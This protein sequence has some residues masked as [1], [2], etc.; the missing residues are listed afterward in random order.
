MTVSRLSA[1]ALAAALLVV[2]GCNTGSRSSGRT[3]FGPQPPAPPPATINVSR[4]ANPSTALLGAVINSLVLRI[5]N[6]STT[7][8]ASLGSLTVVAS[9]TVDESVVLTSATLRHDLNLDGLVDQNDPQLATVAAPAFAANNGSVT[10]TLNPPLQIPTLDA[11]QVI[12]TVET[13]AS[14]GA[15]AQTAF[16]G[17]TVELGV[18]S[19][20]AV[21]LAFG[22][23]PA[24]VGGAFPLTGTA[25]TLGIGTHLLISEVNY[26][27]VGEFIEIF[28]PTPQAIALD[29]YYLSDYTQD[30]AAGGTPTLWYYLLPTGQN[31]GPVGTDFVVRFPAGATIAPGE[32]QIVA[33]EQ[34]PNNGFGN[35]FPNVT[36]TYALRNAQAPTQQMRIFQAGNWVAGNVAGTGELL[37]N[38]GEVLFLFTWNAQAQPATSLITDVDTVGWGETT[39]AGNNYLV[40]KSGVTVN[41]ETYAQETPQATQNGRRLRPAVG[42]ASGLS[43]QRQNYL[44]AGEVQNGNGNGMGGHDETSEDWGANFNHATPTPLG[45]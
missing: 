10:F 19:S 36:P 24:P 18:V 4:V 17:Q 15:P 11:V 38:A 31:F 26:I 43:M 25:V 30:V 7:Q 42:G 20:A 1:A 34:D 41:G 28:N 6:T 13:V 9:G 45:P 33:I 27:T 40:D 44:E 12:V 16:V 35:F 21:G 29:D 8:V 2:V 3:T 14:T 22:T 5:E 39:A 37:T 23:V 32:F